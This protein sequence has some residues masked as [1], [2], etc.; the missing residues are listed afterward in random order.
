M[1]M[2][3]QIRLVLRNHHEMSAASRDLALAAG[4][5]VSLCCLIRL[6]DVDDETVHHLAQQRPQH[7]SES[8]AQE[9]GHYQHIQR[10]FVLL[11]KRIE[12]HGAQRTRPNRYCL[13]YERVAICADRRPRSRPLLDP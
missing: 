10:R 1:P 4:A 5:G 9:D 13:T 8:H 6:N 3:S 12:A 7:D 11:S 2:P